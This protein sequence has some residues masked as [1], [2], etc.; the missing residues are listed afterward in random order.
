MQ[1]YLWSFAHLNHK[2]HDDAA[3]RA[4]T[5]AALTDPGTTSEQI[6]SSLASSRLVQRIRCVW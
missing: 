1:Y 3:L 5:R 4:T 6:V 2:K